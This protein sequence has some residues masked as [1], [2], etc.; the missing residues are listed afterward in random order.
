MQV[1]AKPSGTLLRIVHGAPGSAAPTK[2]SVHKERLCVS[3]CHA[4]RRVVLKKRNGVFAGA[5]TPRLYSL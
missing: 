5:D 4:L 3:V 1:S 2:S